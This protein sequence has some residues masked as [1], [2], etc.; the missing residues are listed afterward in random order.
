MICRAIVA[1]TRDPADRGRIRVM[2]PSMTGAAKGEWVW[3]V[4]SAGYIVT[5]DVGDQVWVVF[6]NGD[7]ESPVWLGATQDA[8]GYRTLLE[9]VVDLEARVSD[10]E[11]SA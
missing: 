10:L 6:E 7:R 1:D 3:P 2:I 11:G 4:V 9:R 5:P 8:P